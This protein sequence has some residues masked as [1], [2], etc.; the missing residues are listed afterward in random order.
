MTTPG[1]PSSP[2][3]PLLDPAAQQVLHAA[4]SRV[5]AATGRALI[6]P[7]LTEKE[8]EDALKD[9]AETA[10]RFCASFHPGAS[11][12][13]CPRL[14][15][16]KLNGDFEV[17]EGSYW[18]D[19]ATTVVTEAISADQRGKTVTTLHSGWDTG[20]VVSVAD[21]AEEQDEGDGKDE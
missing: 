11:T 19:G 2:G 10:C 4:R 18:P 6:M 15:T 20:K 5:E 7:R 17:I 8:R 21:A 3:F 14:A 1:V 12:P 16:F 13:A 9:A